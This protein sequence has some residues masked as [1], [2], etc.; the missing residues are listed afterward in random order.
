LHRTPGERFL[1]V[2]KP[3]EDMRCGAVRKICRVA[4]SRCGASENG[5]LVGGEVP[6]EK[7]SARTGREPVAIAS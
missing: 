3:V 4:A 2:G 7:V 6:I 5:L 1:I